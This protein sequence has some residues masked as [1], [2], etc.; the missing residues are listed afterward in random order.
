MHLLST[1]AWL[2]WEHQAYG[3]LAGSRLLA[4]TVLG[5]RAM[6]GGFCPLSP[7]PFKNLLGSCVSLLYHPLTIISLKKR[8]DTRKGTMQAEGL[9]KKRTEWILSMRLG[10]G[11]S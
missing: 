10:A 2:T 8:R 6:L 11:D 7:A 1:C 9:W 5:R 3:V 4:L